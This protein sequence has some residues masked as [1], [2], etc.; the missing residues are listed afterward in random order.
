MFFHMVAL[1]GLPSTARQGK[2]QC[3]SNLQVSAY[4]MFAPVSLDKVNHRAKAESLW[5]DAAKGCGKR[6]GKNLQ[7]LGMDFGETD[8]YTPVLMAF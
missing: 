4:F 3:T 7:S 5:K 8:F 6:E 2:S 1:S